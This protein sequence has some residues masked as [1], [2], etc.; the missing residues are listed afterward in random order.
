MIDIAQLLR[1]AQSQGASDLH[2]VANT[3]PTLRVN[4]SLL[5]MN[6]AALAAEELA[7]TC[8][9]L[10]SEEQRARFAAHWE[11]DFSF[12]VEGTGRYRANL[13]RERGHVEAAFRILSSVVPELRGLGLPPVLEELVRRNQG[14]ILVTG[15]TGA[16][17]STTLA[18]MVNQINKQRRCMMI[19]IEDPIEYLFVNENSIIKQRE[20]GLDTMSFPIALR[21]ALRQDPDVIVVGEMRDLDTIQTALTAAETGHLVLATIHTPDVSQTVD[22]IIDVFPPHQQSQVRLQFANTI[23]GIVAQQ[24]IPRADGKGRVVAVEVLVATV[25]IRKLL[26]SGKNE[27]LTTALETGHD[28]GMITMDKSLLGLVQRGIIPLD[29]AMARCRFPESFRF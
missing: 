28:K 18:A 15:P 26:R 8:L 17:K 3:A 13:H 23:E 7:Q 22:R 9:A 11:L 4:G 16:G 25:G 27:Q 21:Q 1:E 6:G 14:M 24:L 2:L 5:P 29:V 20:I 10:L 19:T 12:V